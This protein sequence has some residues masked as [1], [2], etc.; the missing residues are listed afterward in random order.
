VAR[1]GFRT[2]ASMST[3]IDPYRQVH[4]TQAGHEVNHELPDFARDILAG[5]S[6]PTK[7]IPG[8]WRFDTRGCALHAQATLHEDHYPARHEAQVLGR[9]A[10]HIADEAGAGATLLQ[11]GGGAP[12]AQDRLLRALDAPRCYRPL[13]H[14][15]TW[16]AEAVHTAE[17]VIPAL[18]VDALALDFTQP[19]ALA[20]LG[21]TLAS[22][23][24]SA[25]A[26]SRGRRIGFVPALTLSAFEPLQAMGLL[27]RIGHALGHDAL[28]VLGADTNA[29]EASLIA[30]QDDHQGLHAAFNLN[31]LERVN[32]ELGADFHA[33]TFRHEARF[34]AREHR[35]QSH[36]V[37]R[38]TQR[39]SLAGRSVHFAIGESIHVGSVQGF[40]LALTQAIAR[41]AGWWHRQ[42]WMDGHS[43]MAVHVLERMR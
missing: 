31:L 28:L 25:Q 6:R 22:S 3:V 36:L 41:R 40:S 33:G 19:E 39:V 42:F 4:S 10:R 23:A 11:F 16:L 26:N 9:C 30:A 2:L 18:P 37:S 7:Q 43:R 32:R 27:G 12:E 21:A 5:L 24:A 35:L 8:H 29:D 14:R 13:E 1:T 34:D 38:Y 15:E 20:V 17:A